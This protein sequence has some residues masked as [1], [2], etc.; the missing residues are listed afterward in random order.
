MYRQMVASVA[1]LNEKNNLCKII[2]CIICGVSIRGLTIVTITP[3]RQ[4]TVFI[5]CP[6]NI[7]TI[8][9]DATIVVL[10]YA[11]YEWFPYS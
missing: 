8:L 4:S 11:K 2:L 7:K 10:C 3:V 5:C 1:F 9:K 6:T